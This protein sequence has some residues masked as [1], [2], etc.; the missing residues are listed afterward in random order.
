MRRGRCRI[1]LKEEV[2]LVFSLVDL[3]LWVLASGVLALHVCSALWL[4]MWICS[5]LAKCDM[6]I[7]DRKNSESFK[8]MN[9]RLEVER[10]DFV[11][12]IETRSK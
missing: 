5:K 3:L 11:P 4:F 2:G 9:S 8:V 12:A 1:A 7:T 6:S 10:M